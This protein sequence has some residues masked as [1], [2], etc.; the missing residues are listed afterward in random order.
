MQETEAFESGP[1]DPEVVRR[2]VA[3][4]REFLGFLEKRVPNRNVAEEILQSAFVRTLERGSQ[5]ESSESAVAWFYRLL[6]NAIVDY[7]RRRATEAK[8]LEREAAEPRLPGE[9]ELRDAICACMNELLPTL[10]PEYAELL[11]QVDLLERPVGEVAAE[12]HITPNNASVRLHRA[13]QGL[14]R[15]LEASCG[16][17]AVHG[18]LDC[19]CGGA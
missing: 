15:R 6:R 19:S 3:S 4:H 11:R 2:L 5:L 8:V 14:K 7:Y 13:R 18:C 10:K 9:A 1:P 12:L 17:C 16:T